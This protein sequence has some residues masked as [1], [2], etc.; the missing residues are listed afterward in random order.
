LGFRETF[1]FLQ[2]RSNL[3]IELNNFF[4]SFE[5]VTFCIN[6]STVVFFKRISLIGQQKR[7]SQSD[8]FKILGCFS[9]IRRDWGQK[10]TKICD[11]LK[12]LQKHFNLGKNFEQML[13]L[14]FNL[15]LI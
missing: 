13:N 7:H 4:P 14:S 2:K 11:N 12:S 9:N 3:R 6:P 10:F 5:L 1:K 15:A 8:A